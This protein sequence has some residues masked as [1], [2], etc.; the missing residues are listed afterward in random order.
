MKFI[1]KFIF[2]AIS[3]IF[4]SKILPG[5][6]LNGFST[7][8]IVVIAMSLC[9]AILKPAL[10]LLTLP[11]TILTLGLFLLVIN[12]IIVFI[13]SALVPGFV[14]HGFLNALIFSFLISVFNSTFYKWIEKDTLDIK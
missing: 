9:N 14:V 1:L 8:M 7:A 6:Y 3:V 5:I 13:V 4:A 10:I 2:A 12:T 11:I